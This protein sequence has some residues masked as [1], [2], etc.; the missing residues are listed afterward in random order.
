MLPAWLRGIPDQ[1]D[2]PAMRHGDYLFFLR[3]PLLAELANLFVLLSLALSSLIMERSSAVVRS[4]NTIGG[5]GNEVARRGNEF[6]FRG[7]KVAGND[8]STAWSIYVTTA[9]G[10]RKRSREARK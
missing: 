3:Q 2:S 4:R 1:S 10:T 5:R 6:E 8:I 9:C 7:S